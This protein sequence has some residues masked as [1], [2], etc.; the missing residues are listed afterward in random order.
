MGAEM[1]ARLGVMVNWANY[2]KNSSSRG[3]GHEGPF[4]I[5]SVVALRN[6]CRVTVARSEPMLFLTHALALRRSSQKVSN[7][8]LP[9][10]PCSYRVTGV[11]AWAASH[12][13]QEES[14]SVRI[15]RRFDILA[16]RE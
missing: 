9:L 3:E 16:D 15:A 5:R 14:T 2:P 11:V 12:I 13:G 4:E 8:L 6:D 1:S 10:F 7:G